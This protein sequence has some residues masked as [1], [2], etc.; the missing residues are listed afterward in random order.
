[1]EH[2]NLA[3]LQAYVWYLNLMLL[4]EFEAFNAGGERFRAAEGNFLSYL[5]ADVLIFDIWKAYYGKST[6]MD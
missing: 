2:I 6:L 5:V 4:P 1:M 3:Y